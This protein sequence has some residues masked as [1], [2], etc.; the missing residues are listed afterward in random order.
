[1]IFK[2]T[3]WL[4][5]GAAVHTPT[6]IS[7]QDNYSNSIASNVKEG[8]KTAESPDGNFNYF[9]TT[10]FRALGSV[11]FVI[12]RR[13]L[14]NADYEYVSY[15]KARLNSTPNVFS[16]IN[17]FIQDEYKA[18]G[19]IRIGGELR[20][21]PFT[22]RGGY[23]LYGS[24]FT[25]GK[26]IHANRSNYTAGVGFRKNSF[27]IDFATVVATYKDYSFLY[28]PSFN[29]AVVENQYLSLNFL[30]TFGFRF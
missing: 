17:S 5:F 20:I 30:F 19:N 15:G 4:R 14:I 16:Q 29:N 8:K 10:P 21:D 6:R 22:L 18:A 2:A 25:K 1:M 24:P 7:I 11:G 26:N 9:I 23:A 27:F 12:G 13:G 3:D 28:D